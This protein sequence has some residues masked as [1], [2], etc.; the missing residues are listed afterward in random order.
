MRFKEWLDKYEAKIKKQRIEVSLFLLWVHK[1]KEAKEMKEEIT[2]LKEVIKGLT[3]KI[4]IVRE[5]EV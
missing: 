1:E 3:S 5:V 4:T 2:F